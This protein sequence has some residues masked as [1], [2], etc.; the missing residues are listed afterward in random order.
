[1]ITSNL[2]MPLI[3]T[4]TLATILF[5][6]LGFL[7]HPSRAAALWSAAFSSA[8]VGSYMWL[9][10]EIWGST[11]FRAL[12]A[13]LA[14]APMALIWS[15]L[16]ARRRARR[17]FIPLSVAYLIL[18]PAALMMSASSPAYGV[19]FRVVFA[20]TAVFA[21]LTI[22]ELIRLGTHKRDEAYPLLAA[23]AAFIVFT[24]VTVVD[25][26][27]VARHITANPESLQFLRTINMIG[28]V[29]FVI[30]ALVTTLLLTVR[31]K[32]GHSATRGTF[33]ATVR[34]RLNR[35][36]AANDPWWSMLDIRLDD[37][38]GIRAAS[39]TAAF[40][41]TSERFAHDVDL[42]LPADADIE[43]MSATRV[44][45]LVPRA[46]GGLREILSGLLERISTVDERQAVPIRLSASIG[47]AQVQTAGYG[48]D[49]L[50]LAASDA[51]KT[52]QANG[53]DRWERVRNTTE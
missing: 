22:V 29:V 33:E 18:M 47:W 40:N 11:A 15:G 3:A 34:N 51:V 28:I 10:Y 27:L 30:C 39:S 49:E 1:M 4:T 13:G 48:F 17:Q 8:M 12:G 31:S 6:A 9:A 43:Q 35:A 5:I 21:A 26:V 20:T 19:A 44:I 50:L 42:A 25:G 52:A 2:V 24:A 38:D 23:C 7:P 32:G 16:R 37:P 14:I 36:E 53:G 45:A 46:Q 41:S